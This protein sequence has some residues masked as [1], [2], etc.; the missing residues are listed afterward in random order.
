MSIFFA[1]Y[2]RLNHKMADERPILVLYKFRFLCN[3]CM[4]HT[5]FLY[6][7]YIFSKKDIVAAGK[8][9][10]LTLQVFFKLSF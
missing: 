7:L 6:L 3:V 1:V 8:T 4:C 2:V 5:F 10:A 9:N